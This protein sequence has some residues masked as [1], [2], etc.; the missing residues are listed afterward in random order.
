M[1]SR[2]RQN[3]VLA[4]FAEVLATLRVANRAFPQGAI[5]AGNMPGLSSGTRISV[6]EGYKPSQTIPNGPT[7]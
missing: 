5:S 1:S 6:S 4:N 7:E 3:L 2:K